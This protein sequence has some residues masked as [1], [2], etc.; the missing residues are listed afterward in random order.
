MVEFFKEGGAGMFPTVLFGFLFFAS[1]VLYTLRPD[2]KL[3]PIVVALGAVTLAS[4][5]LG[6]AMGLSSTM[7]YLHKVEP[8]QQLITGA[9]GVAESLNNIILALLLFLPSSLVAAVG[10]VRSSSRSA[11]PA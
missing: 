7:G 5:V 9:A 3:G 11:A 4:G 2:R 1:A 8:A 10:A 6:L